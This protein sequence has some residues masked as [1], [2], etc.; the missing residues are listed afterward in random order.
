MIYRII[1]ALKAIKSVQLYIFLFILFVGS[2]FLSN[3]IKIYF[4]EKNIQIENEKA[5]YDSIL[6]KIKVN[7]VESKIENTKIDITKNELDLAKSKTK[8]NELFEFIVYAKSQM[9]KHYIHW[10]V[11]INFINTNI[12]NISEI[13]LGDN[14]IIFSGKTNFVQLMNDLN[15]IEKLSPFIWISHFHFNLDNEYTVHL[16][17]NGALQ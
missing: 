3:E 11:L 12:S 1:E 17:F 9:N 13:E 4:E 7:E 10:S 6:K 14:K 5:S 15:K 8:E 16:R 2:L